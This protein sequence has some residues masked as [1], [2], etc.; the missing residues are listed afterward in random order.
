MIATTLILHNSKLYTVEIILICSYLRS[1]KVDFFFEVSMLKK[2]IKLCITLC[3]HMMLLGMVSE[4]IFPGKL[5]T[6]DLQ[7]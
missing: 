5:I 2:N 6:Y 7:L 1:S 4:L 3:Q